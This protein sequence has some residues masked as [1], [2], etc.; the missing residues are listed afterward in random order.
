MKKKKQ[1]AELNRSL[2]AAVEAGD[3][4]R[5]KT[6]VRSGG[7][8]RCEQDEPVCAASRNGHLM[9]VSY[10]IEEAGADPNAQDGYVL[11]AAANQGHLAIVRYL[12]ERHGVGLGSDDLLF[13]DSHPLFL[14]ASNDHLP[15]VKYLIEERGADPRMFDDECVC[16]AAKCGCL[17]VLKYLLEEHNIDPYVR[18]NWLLRESA[19]SGGLPLV[20]YLVE[21]RGV[22]PRV[23]ENEA[24]V[25]AA[26]GG[27]IEV[28]D[29]LAR[30]IFD[31][32][33]WRGKDRATID[34]EAL[35]I[36]AKIRASPFMTL[37]KAKP[38]VEIVRRHALAAV[39]QL[40]AEEA[41]AK[42]PLK[43]GRATPTPL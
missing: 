9:L 2:L 31:P 18:D 24:I 6:V 32:A 23:R 21:E 39:F 14:A 8:P 43:L 30:R 17:L 13:P 3:L 7:D 10:L 34:A 40:R 20:K 27:D 41:R 15:V 22:D 25:G 36:A 37:E 19:N 5:V 26:D 35:S 11:A 1:R 29:Y 12:V 42:P 33:L 28:V 4:A 38:F 16:W